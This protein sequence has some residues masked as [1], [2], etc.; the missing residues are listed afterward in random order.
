MNTLCTRNELP[1]NKKKC[2]SLQLA[3]TV[4]FLDEIFVFLRKGQGPKD[5]NI[6]VVLFYLS[7]SF[8]SRIKLRQVIGNLLQVLFNSC[9]DLRSV[10]DVVLC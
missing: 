5:Q 1:K 8:F 7:L 4:Q 3:W 6:M 2:E 9:H 10:I